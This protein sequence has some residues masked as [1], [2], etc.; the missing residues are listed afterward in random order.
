MR[1]GFYHAKMESEA[2]MEANE[3]RRADRYT[4]GAE[5]RAHGALAK[6]VKIALA[7]CWG[8]ALP[9]AGLALALIV[10]AVTLKLI[11]GAA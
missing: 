2:S 7:A 4:N 8:F 5:V 6:C 10:S 3:T 9:A 11:G 1:S